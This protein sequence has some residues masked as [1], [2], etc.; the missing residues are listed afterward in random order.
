MRGF[1]VLGLALAGLACAPVWSGG[2]DLT[3]ANRTDAALL[4]LAMDAESARL[5]DPNPLWRVADHLERL[6]E[7]GQEV[8]IEAEGYR[9]GRGVTV[10]LYAVPAGDRA[11]AMAP[12]VEVVTLTAPQLRAAG[13]RVVVREL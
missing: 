8:A 1:L 13:Y 2:A 5:V 11:S 10:F 6:V 7:P 9:R 3:L 4:Y 12:L